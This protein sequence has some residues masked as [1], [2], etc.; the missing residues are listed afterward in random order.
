VCKSAHGLLQGPATGVILL[1]LLIGQ[2]SKHPA[3]LQPHRGAQ[4]AALQPASAPES[5]PGHP[6][7]GH[8]RTIQQ[9]AEPFQGERPRQGQQQELDIQ[10]QQADPKAALDAQPAPASPGIVHSNQKYQPDPSQN[11]HSG[12]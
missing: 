3:A 2:E 9:I 10:P 8:H 4:P 12:E 5:G 6:G 1:R 7:G 11:R